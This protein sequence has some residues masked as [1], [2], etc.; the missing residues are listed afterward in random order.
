VI[1]S[2]RRR[3]LMK[4]SSRQSRRA[5]R[6]K[7]DNS[8]ASTLLL[9]ALCGCCANR[10]ALAD[11]RYL[12]RETPT[13]R[14]RHHLDQ[15]IR[16]LQPSEGPAQARANASRSDAAVAARAATSKNNGDPGWQV[17]GRGYEKLLYM[18]LATSSA[19]GNA[20]EM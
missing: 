20:D 10:V 5:V 19:N 9:N 16:I 4:S 1:D 18:E 11:L 12:A 13:V 2:Y 8:R 6:T 3:W 17:L 7:A 15:Q 14:L